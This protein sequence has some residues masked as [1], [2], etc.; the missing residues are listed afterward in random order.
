LQPYLKAVEGLSRG[1]AETGRYQVKEILFDGYEG[2]NLKAFQEELEN[3]GFDIIVTIGP[4]ASRYMAARLPGSGVP[5]IYSMLLDPQNIFYSPEGICGVSLN[6][7]IDVQLREIK[8]TL[9]QIHFIGVLCDPKNN[10]LFLEE[11]TETGKRLGLQIVPVAVKDKK[12]IPGALSENWGNIEVLWIIPDQTI[13]SESIVQYVIKEALFK[14]VPVI[15]YN[16]FFYDYGAALAFVLDYE[17]IGRRTSEL[18][19]DRMES[20]ICRNAGPGYMLLVNRRVLQQ[21]DFLSDG[22]QQ[23]EN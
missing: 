1:L 10:A 8:K 4:E 19:R 6:I 23:D 5:V 20:G 2:N 16:R 12:K 15:G 7:P 3:K 21:V 14:K 9:P 22:L 13:I 18:I 17:Q 11:A